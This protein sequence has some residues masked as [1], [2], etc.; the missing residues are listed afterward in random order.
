[1]A[2]AS[3]DLEGLCWECLLPPMLPMWSSQLFAKF[4]PAPWYRGCHSLVPVGLCFRIWLFGVHSPVRACDVFLLMW[5]PSVPA[6]IWL[7]N[8]QPRLRRED[9]GSP[10]QDCPKVWK[11]HAV[12]VLGLR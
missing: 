6:G 8:P 9:N 2:A 5:F 10:S 4:L 1:M 3:H 7:A 11:D 12:C